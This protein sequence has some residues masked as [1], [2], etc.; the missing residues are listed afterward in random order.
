MV[1]K[2]LAIAVTTLASLALAA[3]YYAGLNTTLLGELAVLGA[4]TVSMLLKAERLKETPQKA[5]LSRLVHLAALAVL[6]GCILFQAI[7][8]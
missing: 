5:R 3:G 8:L 1:K 4:V 2:E 7:A 6:S